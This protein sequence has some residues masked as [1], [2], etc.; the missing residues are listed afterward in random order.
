V[1]KCTIGSAQSSPRIFAVRVPAHLIR[2]LI[3]H[4]HQPVVGD[5]P[6]RAVLDLIAHGK[7]GRERDE[8]S[9]RELA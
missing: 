4:R 5:R 3:A 2:Q 9:V 7:P 1:K 6:P 8:E